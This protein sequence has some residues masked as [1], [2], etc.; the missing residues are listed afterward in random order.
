[1]EKGEGTVTSSGTVSLDSLRMNYSQDGLQPQP[2]LGV[3]LF[4]IPELLF[5]QFEVLSKKS[6][7][8]LSLLLFPLYVQLSFDIFLFQMANTMGCMNGSDILI[9]EDFCSTSISQP[10]SKT[11]RFPTFVQFHAQFS[12]SFFCI[13]LFY[14]Q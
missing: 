9:G 14:F 3:S 13:C 10:N 4:L 2:A 8:S 6:L 12:V 5:A 7:L 1:M 11:V